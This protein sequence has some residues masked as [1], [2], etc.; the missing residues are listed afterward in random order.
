[1]ERVL[2]HGG[3]IGLF[4]V[5]ALLLPRDREQALVNP[6]LVINLI[7][8]LL[9]FLLVS[10]LIGWMAE[11]LQLALI[12][13]AWLPSAPLQFLLSF[14]LLDFCRYW[15]HRAHHRV[16]FLWQF[17]RVHHS[18]ERM[19]A[20]S[21]LRMHVVDFI[22]LACIPILLFGV[23][24]DTSTFAPW[25]VPVALGVGVIFDAFQHANLRFS[26]HTPLG[27]AWN[28]L[29]NNP[30]FHAWHH[31]R[32]GHRWDGNYGNTLTV[33]DRMF[34]SDVTQPELPRALGISADQ[35][36]AGTREQDLSPLRLLRAAVVMQL[37]RPR[38]ADEA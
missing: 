2:L 31:T 37:L 21:G 6:D 10:P 34:G 19:D 30:H 32:D 1:M 18:S 26:I 27:R 7:N 15:L 38:S 9:I 24:M 5:L 36:L 23:L 16:P 33:W 11:H 13:M 4:L 20:T 12:D 8:G 17:H 22:Q 35:A 25:V 29:L 14:L 28:L 3:G